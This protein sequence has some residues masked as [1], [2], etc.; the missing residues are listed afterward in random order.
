MKLPGKNALI[1]GGAHRLGRALSLGLAQ[2]GV[3]VAVNYLSSNDEAAKTTLDAQNLGVKALS[4]KADISDLAQVQ[5]MVRTVENKLGSIDILVHSAAPF[6]RTPFPV[7]NID[8]WHHVINTMVNGSF[9]CAN[10]VAPHMLEKGSGAMIFIIDLSALE[11]MQNY[12][13]HSI[14]KAS[15]L[16]LSRQLAVELAPK[17]RVNSIAPGQ[18]LPP[19]DFSKEKIEQSARKNL[20]ERWGDPKD[21]VNTMLFLL[22]NE[23]VNGEMIVVDGGERLGHRRRRKN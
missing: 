4:V 10:T 21:V 12:I 17:V 2:A 15:I 3:N 6:T 18:I 20:L 8:D 22:E 19:P 7:E 13:A 1:T 11:P 5:Q 14:G 23:F 9:Y 16:A